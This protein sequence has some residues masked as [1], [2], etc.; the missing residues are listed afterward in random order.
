MS[1]EKV[2]A[3]DDPVQLAEVIRLEYGAQLPAAPPRE[4]HFDRERRREKTKLV[5]EKEVMAHVN[6]VRVGAGRQVLSVEQEDHVVELVLSAMF[7]LPHLFGILEREPLAEDLMVIGSDPVRVDLATG[8]IKEYPPL[9]PVDEALERVISN[10]AM[11]HHRPFSFETPFVDVQLAP[12]LRF[13]GQGFDVVSRPAI[14][15]RVHRVLGASIDEMVAAGSMSRGIGYMLG[16]VVKEGKLSVAF[17]GVQGSGKT[18]LLRATLLSYPETTRVVTVETDFE[19]GMVGLGRRFTQEMQARLPVT[20]KWQGID[21]AALMPHTLR[22]R[23]DLTVLGE[24]RGQEAPAAIRA[25]GIGQGTMCTVHGISAQAGL[26]QFVDRMGESGT[27]QEIA[28]RMVYGAF[29]IV[30]HCEMNP[31]NRLRWVSEVVAPLLEGGEPKVH[32]L[33]ERSP[34][35]GD[36]R[37]RASKVV[38]P[39]LLSQRIRSYFPDFDEDRARDDTYAPHTRVGVPDSARNGH[40]VHA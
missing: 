9:V 1:P 20:S 35:A 12:H 30:V 24:V 4:S 28:R 40:G 32:H 13:H 38:W 36:M 33:W 22:T 17:T 21:T 5:L 23:A 2:G 26:E 14:F 16:E 31:N 15:I 18:T 7:L 34:Y 6:R 27:P 10:V 25:A 19:L 8:E 37:A 11:D 39:A 3:I 29:D